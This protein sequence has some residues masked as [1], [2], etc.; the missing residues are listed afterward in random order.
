MRNFLFLIVLITPLSQQSFAASFDCKKVS[1]QIERMICGNSILGELDQELSDV[2]TRLLLA[3]EP[4]KLATTKATQRQWLKQRGK[5][6][7]E[8]CLQERYET[9]IG[10]LYAQRRALRVYSAFNDE[11]EVFDE[12]LFSKVPHL[13]GLANEAKPP[14]EDGAAWG[15]E[16]FI[17]E[18]NPLYLVLNLSTWSLYEGAASPSSGDEFVTIQ[19]ERG[20]IVRDRLLSNAHDFSVFNKNLVRAAYKKHFR[21]SS[22]GCADLSEDED[23]SVI[24]TVPS[25]LGLGLIKSTSQ[26]DAAC[27][28][29]FFITW[30]TVQPYLSTTGLKLMKGFV[31]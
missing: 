20:E 5:C 12:I 9:R 25:R 23:I 24:A 13:R 29:P 28:G 21:L 27:A 8:V 22:G 2:Y 16:L 4:S 31:N 15:V 3:S 14:S 30:S 6:S 18:R 26:V 17:W 7:N 11:K 1:T 19:M 10:E